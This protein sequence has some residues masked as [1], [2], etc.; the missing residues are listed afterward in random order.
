MSRRFLPLLVGRTTTPWGG[1]SEYALRRIGMSRFFPPRKPSGGED[2]SAAA[3]RPRLAPTAMVDAHLPLAGEAIY[4][5][6][7]RGWDGLAKGGAT[8]LGGG[9]D[10]VVG[11]DGKDRS[12]LLIL[13][14]CGANAV[15]ILPGM[16][17]P[18][19][20]PIAFTVG[21]G[22]YVLEAAPEPPPLFGAQSHLHCFEAL[23]HGLPPAPRGGAAIEDWHWRYLPAPP[24]VLDPGDDGATPKSGC[25]RSG[26]ARS[27]STR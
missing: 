7:H 21:D 14:K 16:G 9:K 13:Y 4:S 1:S 11:E 25:P 23:V 18:K 5:P 22:V 20:S 24:Y 27:P 12:F 3:D 8:V 10:K 15:R 17:A 6:Q 2:G 26:T 19:R